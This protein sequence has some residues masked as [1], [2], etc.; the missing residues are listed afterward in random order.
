MPGD[1]RFVN[2]IYYTSS[3][4][5][6]RLVGIY[7]GPLINFESLVTITGIFFIYHAIGL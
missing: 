4:I 3:E 6:A 7:I 2:N 1:L 5:D